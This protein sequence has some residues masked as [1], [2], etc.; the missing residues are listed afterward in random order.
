[1]GIHEVCFFKSVFA[2][3]INEYIVFRKSQGFT[4]ETS[5]TYLRR[6]DQYCFA[7]NVQSDALTKEVVDVWV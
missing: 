6:F 7:N 1:M 5:L 4:T 2:N 3:S